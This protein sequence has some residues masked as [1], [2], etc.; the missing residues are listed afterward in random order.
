MREANAG[1]SSPWIDRPRISLRS[2]RATLLLPHAKL[3]KDHV[4]N[5]FHVHPAG[6]L[7]QAGR[8]AAQLLGHQLLAR[9]LVG[10]VESGGK[11]ARDVRERCMLA[12]A[13]DQRRLE[14]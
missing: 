10:E 2:I 5:F 7:A 6:E 3:A 9:A 13:R 12:L 14:L 11:R 1:A 8:G 4:E